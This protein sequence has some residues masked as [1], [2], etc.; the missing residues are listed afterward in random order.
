MRHEEE[1]CI[2]EGVAGEVRYIRGTQRESIWHRYEIAEEYTAPP[3]KGSAGHAMV[4]GREWR[5]RRAAAGNCRRH[6][7][8]AATAAEVNACS[9]A[10]VRVV[11]AAWVSGK[12]RRGRV[13]CAAS[14]RR[15]GVKDMNLGRG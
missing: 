9:H 11:N 12:R 7:C 4:G 1:D 2:H 8:R 5:S 6:G 13:S 10:D 3:P 15:T 14:G